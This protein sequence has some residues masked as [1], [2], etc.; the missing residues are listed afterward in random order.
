M[1]VFA[2][3]SRIQTARDAGLSSRIGWQTRFSS[4]DS[5]S[6]DLADSQRT[7]SLDGD[8][9]IHGIR[10]LNSCRAR[11]ASRHR[12]RQRHSVDRRATQIDPLVA[13]RHE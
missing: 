13:L 6:G 10:A 2:S 11:H 5:G 4:L 9:D 3:R 12:Q 7:G 1:G 8:P